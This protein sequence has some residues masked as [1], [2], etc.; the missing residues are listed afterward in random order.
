[1][2]S[3]R[4]RSLALRRE[5]DRLQQTAGH[6]RL[7]KRAM[8]EDT[9]EQRDL[10]A[11][12]AAG[13]R[14]GDD[15]ALRLLYLRFAD[16]VYSY[17]CSIVQD[18]H[19]AEDVTQTLFARL[20]MALR[21]YQPQVVPFQSWIIRVARNAAIDHVRARRLVPCEEVRDSGAPADDAGG[22]RLEAL[23][24]ALAAIPPEQREVIVLR[25]MGGMSPGE[26]GRRVG[27][28]EDAVHGLQHRG[29]RRLRS[30][31]EQLDAAPVVLAAA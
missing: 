5:A 28:S 2:S 27:R 14:E 29:R 8:S 3:T 1:M 18:E 7:R 17:V 22:E 16:S 23:R 31:L 10:I 21:R 30:E 11:T 15:E 19:D 13:A 24:V 12:A 25:F 4:T 26:I 9:P 6:G 20:P